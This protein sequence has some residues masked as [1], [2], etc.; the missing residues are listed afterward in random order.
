MSFTVSRRTREIGIRVAL[1]AQP[2]RVIKAILRRPLAQ[3]GLGVAAGG[4]LAVLVAFGESAELDGKVL[5][6]Q[7]AALVVL[8]AALMTGVCLLACIVPIRRALHVE[9][10][11]ALRAEV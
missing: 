3:L 9:P 8:Y 2:R 7:G 4:V 11:E 5:S 10:S 6:A 1:G